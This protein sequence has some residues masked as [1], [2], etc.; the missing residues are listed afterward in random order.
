MNSKIAAEVACY[1]QI[2][3]QELD[4]QVYQTFLEQHTRF[5]P[6]EFILNHGINFSLVL[7]KL[8]FGADM[9][10]DFVYLSK[11]SG[12]WVCVLIEI[13]KPQSK[14]F[15]KNSNDF[16]SDFSR[17]L[18][19]INDWRAWLDSEGNKRSFCDQTIGLMRNP[20]FDHPTEI[21][22]VLVHGRRRETERNSIRLAK[23]RGQ[24]RNDLRIMSFD[25]LAEGLAGKP[26]LYIGVKVK[27]RVRIIS[28]KFVSAN[29]FAWM[30]PEMIEVNETLRA[31]LKSN[32]TQW[33]LYSFENGEEIQTVV[34][35]LK[36]TEQRR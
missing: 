15:K 26:E 2:L 33:S 23:I 8:P 27:E 12:R 24:E 30:E 36:A 14:Y 28:D 31:D 34:R 32:G 21:R 6:R 9:K 17:A 5:I 1:H 29:I 19:Q 22:F 20:G 25:S 11:S 10:S 35:Y 18:N 7:R 16:H 4:E 13:E 3:D